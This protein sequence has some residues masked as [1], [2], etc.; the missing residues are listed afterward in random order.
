MKALLLY[1]L[2]FIIKKMLKGLNLDHFGLMTLLKMGLHCM[3]L[4]SVCIQQKSHLYIQ[5]GAAVSSSFI[6]LPIQ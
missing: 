2:S 6:Y 5:H 3:M 4:I 1:F